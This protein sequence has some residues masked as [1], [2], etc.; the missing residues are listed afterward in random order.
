MSEQSDGYQ[1]LTPDVGGE[2]DTDQI[3][4]EDSLLERGVDDL[5]DEGYTLP[6]R[7]RPT[8][9][10]ETPWEEAHR[11]TIDQRILQ[12]EPEVWEAR[13]H[14]SGEREEGR[15]GRLVQ[16][17]TAVRAGATDTFALD[18]GVSGGGASAEEAA[19]H[20]V[21]EEYVDETR[22]VEDDEP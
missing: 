21:E 18:A 13:P 5:L 15:A 9:Y 11:E 10:G 4:R 3:P 22:Y 20:L 14:I 7:P 17:D 12:E 1:G 19:V 8:H 2:G 6:E 16:D